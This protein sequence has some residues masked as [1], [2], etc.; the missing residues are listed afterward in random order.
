MLFLA[1]RTALVTQANNAF[2][3][4]LPN[5]TT[6]NLQNEK[7]TDGRV[8]VSTYPTMMNLINATDDG[9]R[10]RAGLLRPD[11]DRRGPSLGI[12]NTGRSST[13][14]THYSSAR[15]RPPKDEVDHKYYPAVSPPEDG[16]PT[17]AYGL[18]D[19]AVKEG[20]WFLPA[21]R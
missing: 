14:S 3:T 1:D 7:V 2:K 19:D 15:P 16:V 9:Q 18:D 12:R 17:D 13:G 4:H 11:S 10:L 5:A 20:F 6:V 8:Y 21:F